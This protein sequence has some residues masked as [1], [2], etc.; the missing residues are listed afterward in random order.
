[1]ISNTNLLLD[2]VSYTSDWQFSLLDD[3]E[4]KTLERID[5][6]GISNNKSNWHT[7]AEPIG[8][9]TPGGRNS[10]YMTVAGDGTFSTNNPVFSPDNDGFEDVIFF[11]LKQEEVGNVSQLTI[12]DDFGREVKKI[13]KSELTGTE[14]QVS[15]DGV[16]ENGI[17][18]PL[19]IYFAVVSSFNSN[20]G[21]TYSKRIAFTLAGKLN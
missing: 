18:A 11:T 13:W 9:G 3:T 12:Y 7:A 21:K 17:K 1:L 14:N 15:W 19:G 2:N 5:P 16:N 4:N 6:N 8:F 10:Q 20:S